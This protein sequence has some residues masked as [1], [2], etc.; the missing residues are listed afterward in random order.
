MQTLN[1]LRRHLVN[2][3][4]L[5]GILSGMGLMVDLSGRQV[6]SAVETLETKSRQIGGASL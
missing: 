4:V 1:T 2:Y 5:L 6:Q 3:I